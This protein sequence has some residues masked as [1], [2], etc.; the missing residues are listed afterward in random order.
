MSLHA[1]VGVPARDRLRLERL[2]QYVARPPVA[3]D[4][5]EQLLDGRLALRL[6]TAGATEPRTS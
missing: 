2:I 4:R 5:L 1:G 3:H 6:K